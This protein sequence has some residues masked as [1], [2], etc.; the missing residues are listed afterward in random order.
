ML[1]LQVRVSNNVHHACRGIGEGWCPS[2]AKS[3]VL[4]IHFATW[5]MDNIHI[6]GWFL[7]TYCIYAWW[8]LPKVAYFKVALYGFE[9]FFWLKPNSQHLPISPPCIK[10]SVSL[11]GSLGWVYLLMTWKRPLANILPTAR[12]CC[13]WMLRMGEVSL[14]D[15]P[16]SD[17]I[18]VGNIWEARMLPFSV[19]CLEGNWCKFGVLC[20]T[21]CGVSKLGH[22]QAVNLMK[23]LKHVW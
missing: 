15:W 8:I 23:L 20:G 3:P 5:D 2:S 6:C 11:V 13:W 17:R 21:G 7:A 19:S 14:E 22:L 9:P 12:S 10:G 18:F 16:S 4:P 1:G